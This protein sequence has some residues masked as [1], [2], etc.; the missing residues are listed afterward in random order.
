MPR[1]RLARASSRYGPEHPSSAWIAHAGPRSGTGSPSA[2][3]SRFPSPLTF[4]IRVDEHHPVPQRIGHRTAGRPRV[5]HAQPHQ[6]SDPRARSRHRRPRRPR[7]TPPPSRCTACAHV[8][9]I[10]PRIAVVRLRTCRPAE[11]RKASRIG[12]VALLQRLGERELGAPPRRS[13][14]PRAPPAARW[15]WA[16]V[17][18]AD[19]RSA[20]RRRDLVPQPESPATSP[21]KLAVVTGGRLRAMPQS[22]SS[23]EVAAA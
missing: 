18:A 20:G 15:G 11:H 12:R 9:D 8:A 10:R 1:I 21:T 17:R 23:A 16:P 2:S 22:T 19:R 4:T 13:T 14:P 6:R 5:R 3:S 7:S